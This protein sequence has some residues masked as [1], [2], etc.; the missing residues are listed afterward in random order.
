[1][2]IGYCYTESRTIF[3]THA[4]AQAEDARNDVSRRAEARRLYGELGS[5]ARQKATKLGRTR[6]WLM[7]V[8]ILT[9]LQE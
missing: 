1:M 4:D 2:V 8:S 7:E 6:H 9:D 3:L 5:E